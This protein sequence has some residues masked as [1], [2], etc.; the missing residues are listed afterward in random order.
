MRFDIFGGYP[1]LKY[2]LSEK[3]DGSMKVFANGDN[4]G[5]RQKYFTDHQIN[6]IVAAELVH[7]NFVYSANVN[8]AGKIIP[9]TD[10][11]ATGQSNLFLSITVAD[12]FPVYL[13][14]PKTKIIALAHAGWRGIAAGIVKNTLDEM[15]KIG[16]SPA[17]FL[18]A[19]GLGIQ[20]HHFEVRDDIIDKF[21]KYP[22]RIKHGG[23]AMIDLPGIIKDQLLDFGLIDG[24]IEVSG[25]CT[26]CLKDKY[27]SYRRDHPKNIEAMAAYIG[28]M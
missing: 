24:N 22:L 11:L 2:G 14:D 25:E 5:N 13:F 28:M 20:Q 10:A 1:N 23:K 21:S 4:K 27:F 15:V 7:G 19:I 18:C 17:D 8:D 16:G 12:C 6:N 26:Y 3:Q 9:N